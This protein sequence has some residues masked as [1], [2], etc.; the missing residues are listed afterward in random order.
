MGNGT[1]LGLAV[2]NLTRQKETRGVFD[3][4]VQDGLEDRLDVFQRISA[5]IG[6]LCTCFVLQYLELRKLGYSDAYVL[7]RMYAHYMQTYTHQKWE[8]DKIAHDKRLQ[9]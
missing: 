7:G 9:H 5:H 8:A 3:V 2:Q 4:M 6:E 1:E